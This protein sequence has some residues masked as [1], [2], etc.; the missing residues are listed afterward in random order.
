MVS[1]DM[2]QPAVRLASAMPA[3]AAAQRFAFTLLQLAIGNLYAA[4]ILCGYGSHIHKPLWQKL[5]IK[6]FRFSPIL[7]VI[8]N[9]LQRM[10]HS[11]AFRNALSMKSVAFMPCKCLCYGLITEMTLVCGSDVAE[12]LIASNCL[13]ISSTCME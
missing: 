10:R 3:K 1:S 9:S 12:L 6:P 2:P 7:V 8:L 13:T 4:H 11:A 5:G